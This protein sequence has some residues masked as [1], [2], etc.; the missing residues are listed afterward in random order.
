[1]HAETLIDLRR[2]FDCRD[3]T[4]A[5]VTEVSGEPEIRVAD[6]G[7]DHLLELLL[8]HIERSGSLLVLR[9]CALHLRGRQGALVHFLVL[10]KRNSVNLH[11]H[12]GNHIRRF[13]VEYKGIERIDIDLRVAHH[14]SGDELTAGGIIEGLDG[15]VLD[16]LE[17]ADDRFDLF[18]P[19]TETADLD[20]TVLASD[21]LN[22]SVLAVT[23][24]VA[25]AIATKT[26]PGD[27]GFSGFLGV[28]EDIINKI[29]SQKVI[30]I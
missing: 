13:L 24:D 2:Q 14:I 25:R 21:E 17:L 4:E 12:R 1:M 15:C 5:H 19:D 9:L 8:Q 29:L 30:L 10:V 18:K 20:L 26:F 11:G 3:R 27:E 16:A 28:V 6:D 22:R 7:G 23:D